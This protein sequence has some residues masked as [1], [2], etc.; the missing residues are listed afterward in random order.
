MLSD[1]LKT[2][3]A[4]LFIFSCFLEYMLLFIGVISLIG[5]S[6]EGAWGLFIFIYLALILMIINGILGTFLSITSYNQR[7]YKIAVIVSW[8][9]GVV[10]PLIFVVYIIIIRSV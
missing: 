7:K 6:G 8:V 3:L 9:I 10:L 2:T 4:K 5:A 1:K